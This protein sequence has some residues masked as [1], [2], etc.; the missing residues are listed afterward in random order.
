MKILY[1]LLIFNFFISLTTHQSQ[2]LFFFYKDSSVLYHHTY[3]TQLI[4]LT[5][6]LNFTLILFSLHISITAS[7]QNRYTHININNLSAFNIMLSDLDIYIIFKYNFFH[8]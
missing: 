2:T 4:I 5:H 6:N 7:T 8:F 1:K 3:N